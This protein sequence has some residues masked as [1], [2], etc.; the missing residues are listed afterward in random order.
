MS[1]LSGLGGIPAPAPSASSRESRGGNSHPGQNGTGR[2]RL[3]GADKHAPTTP[4][5]DQAMEGSASG[6][7]L[8][9]E[10]DNGR[11]RE[12]RDASSA[13]GEDRP[14]AGQAA[15]NTSQSA[16]AA[17]GDTWPFAATFRGGA[18]TSGQFRFAYVPP[19]TDAFVDAAQSRRNAEATLE[20]LRL[21]QT[22]RAVEEVARISG[23]LKPLPGMTGELLDPADGSGSEAR[24]VGDP[25]G[26]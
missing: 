15:A 25:S 21:A 16:S 26:D 20:R 18:G 11:G 24:V 8:D 6:P 4:D 3:R 13:T 5:G 17:R 14:V 7:S 1:F 19:A 23:T 9:A 10:A 2:A 22:L 12:W